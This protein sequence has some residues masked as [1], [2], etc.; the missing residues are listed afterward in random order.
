MLF[1]FMK[2]FTPTFSIEP[3][4]IIQGEGVGIFWNNEQ[5]KNK[6]YS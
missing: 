5:Y 1:Y 6:K 2:F 3:K 4:E